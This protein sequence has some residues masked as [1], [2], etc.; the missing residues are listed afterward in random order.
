VARK[1]DAEPTAAERAVARFNEAKDALHNF[2]KDPDIKEVLEEMEHLV[3]QYNQKLDDAVRQVKSSLAHS[4]QNKLFIDGIGAQKKFKRFY[5][6]DYLANT[7]PA[8]QFDE[9][10]TERIVYDLDLDRLEQLVRQG[11]VDGMIVEESRRVEEQNPS[12]MPGTPKPFVI[13][14]IPVGDE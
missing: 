11:E 3:E 5:D 13:P 8:D 14:A 1:D 4:D 12:N 6:A 9:F 7:L 2:L 10:G